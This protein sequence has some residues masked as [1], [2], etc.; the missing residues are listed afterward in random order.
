MAVLGT[1]RQE[2]QDKDGQKKD[3]AFAVPGKLTCIH[4]INGRCIWIDIVTVDQNVD[5][6]VS[7]QKLYLISIPRYVSKFSLH[8]ILNESESNRLR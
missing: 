1:Q 6:M 4:N 7:G 2:E 8:I 5:S 3:T